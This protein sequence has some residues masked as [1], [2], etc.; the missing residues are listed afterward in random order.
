MAA[1]QFFTLSNCAFGLFPFVLKK[2]RNHLDAQLTYFGFIFI[3]ARTAISFLSSSFISRLYNFPGAEPQKYTQS[4]HM[5]GNVCMS[6]HRLLYIKNTLVVIKN[7]SANLN[8]P[9]SF[10]PTASVFIC[11]MCLLDFSKLTCFSHSDTLPMEWKVYIVMGYISDWGFYLIQS[12]FIM[13]I[14]FLQNEISLMKA[15]IVEK[16]TTV[17]SLRS[18]K[19]TMNLYS[20]LFDEALS[21]YTVEIFISISNS[22]INSFVTINDLVVVTDRYLNRLTVP[23]LTYEW[24][25]DWFLLKFAYFSC[26][27]LRETM[28]TVWFVVAAVKLQKEVSDHNTLLPCSVL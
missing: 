21:S 9:D 18:V 24:N 17:Q 4:L 8:Y 6:L 12:Q 16:P 19:T 13:V 27:A 2:T 10:F 7:I 26:H 5:A 25:L 15:G 1:A 14:C 22:L 3:A 20:T 28:F 23:Y 11:I